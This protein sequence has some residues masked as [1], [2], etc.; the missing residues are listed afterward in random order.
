MTTELGTTLEHV[1]TTGQHPHNHR[2]RSSALGVVR[3]ILHL[4]EM[5]VAMMAGMPVLFMLRNAIPPSSSFAAA[6]QPGTALFGLMAGVFMTVPMVAWMI[7][8]GH[9]W[10]HSVEMGLAMLVP[11]AALIVPQALGLLA[12]QAW[13]P[14]VGNLVM[15]L[16]MILV[17]L[18]RRDHYT[19]K[20]SHAGHAA[21]HVAG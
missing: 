15:M 16:S 18:Y 3:F 13:F 7:V 17:M 21:H 2:I 14:V 9:G 1:R 10:R 12:Y 6:F 4:L 20:A 8:R 19:G 5:T 11:F